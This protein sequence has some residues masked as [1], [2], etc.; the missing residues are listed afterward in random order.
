MTN[1]LEIHIPLPA[2][3]PDEAARIAERRAREAAVVSLQQAGEISIREAASLLGL[4]YEAYLDC[5]AALGLPATADTTTPD[6]T[7]ALEQALRARK[8]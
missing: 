7:D 8:G 1:T 4:G 6:L 3:V 5:L 2:G